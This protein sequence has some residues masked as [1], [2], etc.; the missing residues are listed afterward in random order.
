MSGGG[1]P[2]LPPT[3][4][5]NT[6]NMGWRKVK[7]AVVE[8]MVAYFTPSTEKVKFLAVQSSRYTWNPLPIPTV[9]EEVVYPDGHF[10][11]WMLDSTRENP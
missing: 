11:A 4:R 6:M 3:A 9:A 7:P 2:T 5:F 10:G 8:G 1:L